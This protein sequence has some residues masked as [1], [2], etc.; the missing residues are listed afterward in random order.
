MMKEWNTFTKRI[1]INKPMDSVYKCWATKSK[2]EEWFLEEAEFYSDTGERK[3]NELV[4]KGD[5]FKWKWSNWEIREEGE[6]LEANGENL[7]SFT[8]GTGG[9]VQIKLAE[10]KGVTEV[11]LIQN[12]IPTDEKSKMDI[13][14]GCSTGWTF[15]MTNLKAY[16]EYGITL[17][18]KGL[19]QAE[20]TDL[21]N[22]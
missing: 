19:Q 2:I 17:H 1:L 13:Y 3:P 11:T 15:W 5:S 12:E 9:N 7:I 22:S 20:T 6:I 4:Q 18:A 21:I 16:L 8:F 10:D 14:V